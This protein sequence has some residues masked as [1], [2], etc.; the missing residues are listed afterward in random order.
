MKRLTLS[1]L[2]LLTASAAFA[3]DTTHRGNRV[4]ILLTPARYEGADDR[5]SS[6]IRKYLRDE[7]QK[8]GFDAFE[9]KATYDDLNRNMDSA[10]DYYVEIAASDAAA[11]SHGGVGVGAGAVAVDVSL[12]VAHVAAEIRLYDG[13]SLELVR[14]FELDHS[15]KGVAPTSIG[16]GVPGL[17]GWVSVPVMEI[18]QFKRAAHEV[19]RDAAS[20][21]AEYKQ[22]E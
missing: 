13:R 1:L 11:D 21:I 5:M 14:R 19:A 6:A 20:R 22:A 4:G 10:A 18:A 2:V 9:A 15:K 3:L 7:L 17:L 8:S 16:I 12:V